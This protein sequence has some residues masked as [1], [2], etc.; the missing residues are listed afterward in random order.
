MT[1]E[2][3]KIE[4]FENIFF[5]FFVFLSEEMALMLLK[6]LLFFLMISQKFMFSSAK[7]WPVP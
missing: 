4:I 6:N 2:R 7:I 5:I 3:E 1:Q